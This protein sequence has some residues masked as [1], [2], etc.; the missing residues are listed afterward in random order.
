MK[1]SVKES[2]LS[3]GAQPHTQPS[4]ITRAPSVDYVAQSAPLSNIEAHEEIQARSLIDEMFTELTGKRL[5]LKPTGYLIAVKIYV[6]PEELASGVR[7]DGSKYVIW[8]PPA[9]S[10]EDRYR[11]VSALVV[12][13]GPDAYK[14]TLADGTPR[15]AH[16]W[17]KEGDWV[18]IPRYECYQITFKGIPMGM[19]PDDKIMAVIEDPTDVVATI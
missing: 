7:A 11:S 12:A 3:L 2:P 16:P 10:Q 14:G 15:F 1:S 13:V 18:I 6:R 5:T 9:V 19:L 8:T 17:C 4:I